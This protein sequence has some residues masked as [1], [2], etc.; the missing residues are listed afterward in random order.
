MSLKTAIKAEDIRTTLEE[1]LNLI[2]MH[3]G[4]KVICADPIIIE[5]W[6]LSLAEEL[7]SIA[8]LKV[9]QDMQQLFVSKV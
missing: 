4:Q 6:D 9:L 2:Q 5:R 1:H 7:S 3:K 8:T